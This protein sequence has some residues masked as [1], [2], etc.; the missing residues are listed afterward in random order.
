MPIRFSGADTAWTCRNKRKIQAWLLHVIESHAKELGEVEVI[1]CSDAY[2]L[3][4]NR[5]SL[6]HNYY[7]DIITFDY[8]A[9]D[10]ISGDLFV[11]LDR[12]RE[13]AKS[14]AVSFSNEL[15]RVLVHGVLHLCGWTDSSPSEKESMRSQE[16]H[17]L[18][19]FPS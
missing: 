11:S 18:S 5:L 8:C 4:L 15:Y 10:L 17:W 19:E 6:N 7:T 3:E 9:G 13:N 14:G 16:D 12:V 1:F 2:L